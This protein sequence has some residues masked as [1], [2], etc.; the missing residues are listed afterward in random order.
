MGCAPLKLVQHIPRMQEQAGTVSRRSCAQSVLSG[1]WFSS[2]CFFFCV[3]MTTLHLARTVHASRVQS[4]SKVSHRCRYQARLLL[5]K[6]GAAVKQQCCFRT[7]LP[8]PQE[9]GDDSPTRQP[10]LFHACTRTSA[11]NRHTDLQN[12]VALNVC[13]SVGALLHISASWCVSA[14]LV[15]PATY[16]LP[17]SWLWDCSQECSAS[18]NV[19]PNHQ[20]GTH[21]LYTR[22]SLQQRQ[23]HP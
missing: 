8:S 4:G 19:S 11:S 2:G 10:V 21:K 7:I 6:T 15:S 5:E 3:S 22:T 12:S 17:T 13:S 9:R 1:S 16:K 14:N 18:L 23:S 20:S